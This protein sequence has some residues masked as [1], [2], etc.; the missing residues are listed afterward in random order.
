MWS[1]EFSDKSTPSLLVLDR[2]SNLL[3]FS[4]IRDKPF[5]LRIRYRIVAVHQKL[6]VCSSLTLHLNSK[7]IKPVVLSYKV[8]IQNIAEKIHCCVDRFHQMIIIIRKDHRCISDFEDYR[9][10]LNNIM[11]Q[12]FGSVTIK[13]FNL[14]ER[15]L[16]IARQYSAIIIQNL[17]CVI[18]QIFNIKCH[19]NRLPGENSIDL[20][21]CDLQKWCILYQELLLSL[22]QRPLHALYL[23]LSR[24][25]IK[26]K[27]SIIITYTSFKSRL[28]QFIVNFTSYFPISKRVCRSRGRIGRLSCPIEK[29]PICRI[30]GSDVLFS[31]SISPSSTIYSLYI[32]KEYSNSKSGGHYCS[33]HHPKA[34]EIVS[35]GN[36]VCLARNPI[37]SCLFIILPIS[38]AFISTFLYLLTI[39][40]I[41]YGI[42]YI[43]EGLL[44][45]F[46]HKPSRKGFAIFWIGIA[47]LIGGYFCI[48]Y[49]IFFGNK[50]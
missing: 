16:V 7:S 46:K 31:K 34:N 35:N 29:Y 22:F 43:L 10:V 28:R 32:V 3:Y 17:C 44:I 26:A 20:A 9:V 18:T 25:T 50:I 24:C 42:R 14:V 37:C 47:A 30:G 33:N 41:L 6:P 48:H 8:F 45:I 23:L 5:I 19:H 1:F 49:L 13:G 27:S 38:N 2:S 36:P 21:M 11:I 12:Y 39:V 40:F 4:P 15:C